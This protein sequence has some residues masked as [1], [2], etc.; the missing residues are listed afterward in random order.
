MKIL[1]LTNND[2]SK[3]LSDWLKAQGEEVQIWEERLTLSQIEELRP[4]LVISF[5]YRFLIKGEVIQF[6]QGKI[7]NL[8]TS[9][10]PWNRGS[11][12][13]FWSF[14]EDSPK[15]VTI[16]LVDETLDTGAYLYQEEVFFDENKE[17]FATTYDTLI[18]RM[19]AMFQK[20][21]AEIKAWDIKPYHKEETGSY[22]TMKDY[23]ALVDGFEF[24]WKDNIAETKKHLQEFKMNRQSVIGI[25]A[26]GNGQI[27]LG[28]VMRC[29]SI[30]DALRKRG[31]QVLFFVA[32]ENARSVIEARGI[33]VICLGSDWQNLE[34]E[35]ETLK[36]ELLKRNVSFLL[37]DTYS[38]TP[39]YF[40]ALR[41][42]VKTG[43]VD[44]LNAFDMN[45]DVLINYSVYAEDMGYEKKVG[46]TY[47]LGTRYAPLREQFQK[48]NLAPQTGEKRILVLSGGTDPYHMTETVPQAILHTKSL[49]DYQIMVVIGAYATPNEELLKTGR[50]TFYQNVT[51]MAG[52]MREAQMAVSAGGS[53][54]YELC[55]CQIPTVT[56][57][58]VDN[59]LGN[60]EKFDALGVMP[61]A[62]DLRVDAKAVEQSIVDAL[63]AFS[64]EN[65]KVRTRA[66]KELV[67]GEGA[68]HIA[69][70]IIRDVANCVP[71]VS[72]MQQG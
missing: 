46:T 13:N 61:Y 16:H 20:H 9:L 58:F 31:A 66:M 38:V 4:D 55:A 49:D 37:I 8:H 25:R 42:V 26:D 41:K 47:L 12:P 57:A 71:D 53:T 10:L 15:G 28:H 67:D 70:V 1:F 51:N 64:K 65:G 21:W 44:D 2:N 14:I 34:A 69:E 48:R 50:V 56:Y 33:E 22:H 45:V 39:A 27:G 52:L 7:L 5:N 3:G 36:E 29:L 32:D 43:Y 23:H 72:P 30:A 24:S 54:L 18:D 6:M 62:G 35:F 59:Q 17:T 11:S 63:V 19:V 40:E 68:G 60:V